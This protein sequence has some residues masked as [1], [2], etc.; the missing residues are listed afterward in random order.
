MRRSSNSCPTKA[1]TRAARS[2]RCS[3]IRRSRRISARRMARKADSRYRRRGFSAAV[4]GH[5]FIVAAMK[6]GLRLAMI[7]SAALAAVA[8]ASAEFRPIEMSIPFVSHGG[9]RDWKAI[10]RDTLYVQD[11]HNHWYR[12][13]LMTKIGRAHV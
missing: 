6:Q 7:A 11:N 2:T 5:V 13:E 3:G 1:S 4:Q 10:D 12:A 9:I 8:P